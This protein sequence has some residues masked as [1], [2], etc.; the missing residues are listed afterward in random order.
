M[1]LYKPNS[2]GTGVGAGRKKRC[3]FCTGDHSPVQC[4]VVSDPFK[5]LQI[6]QRNRLCFNCLMPNHRSE[7]CRNAYRCQTCK[8]KHHTA[9]HRSPGRSD[10]FRNS[11]GVEPQ[12]QTQG[13]T[14]HSML[15][16][17][18][19]YQPDNKDNGMC[20][21]RDTLSASPTTPTP[22]YQ[23]MTSSQVQDQHRTTGRTMMRSDY[24]ENL[25]IYQRKK[26]T[27]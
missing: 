21:I 15:I 4:Q 7:I 5:R 16:G 25:Q 18:S 12:Y 13:E 19:N 9:L 27:E 2:A 10:Q 23:A 14:Q 3:V 1:A 22:S 24:E 17:Q 8:G 20:Y 6:A 11:T 26:K